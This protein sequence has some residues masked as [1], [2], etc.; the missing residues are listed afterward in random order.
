[1]LP[2]GSVWISVIAFGLVYCNAVTLISDLICALFG[3]YAA[4]FV[5]RIYPVK[6]LKTS[7]VSPG[8]P[9]NLVFA[10]RGKSWKTVFYCLYEPWK[11]L[12]PPIALSST[13][14]YHNPGA[15]HG[16]IPWTTAASRLTNC[17]L[18]G[19]SRPVR[20]PSLDKC[21]FRGPMPVQLLC[22]RSCTRVAELK[23]D[24]IQS[25][26]LFSFTS[27]LVCSY[28]TLGLIHVHQFTAFVGWEGFCRLDALSLPQPT[29][30]PK[31]IWEVLRRDPSCREWTCLLHVLLAVQ[32][33]P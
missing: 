12:L 1:M 18:N 28:F 7:F 22:L 20:R 3:P 33:A 8:K 31:I 26:S 9:W 29:C 10:S 5:N 2:F 11:L 19:C 16:A 23:I 4:M 24:Q 27:V 30:N 17:A 15:A 21:L 25:L 6:S 13:H 32:C 14:S